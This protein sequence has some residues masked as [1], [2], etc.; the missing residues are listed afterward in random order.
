MPIVPVHRAQR[1]ELCLT[2]GERNRSLWFCAVVNGRGDNVSN[3][4][5]PDSRAACPVGVGVGRYVEHS[6]ERMRNAELDGKSVVASTLEVAY[7]A[8]HP[9]ADIAGRRLQSS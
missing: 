8:L 9:G 5:I 2:Q 1:I 6:L 4:R 7:G 3:I